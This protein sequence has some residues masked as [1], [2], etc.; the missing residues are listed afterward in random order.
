[1]IRRME[2]LH[3]SIHH[4]ETTQ[5]SVLMHLLQTAKHTTFGKAHQFSTIEIYEDYA[6]RVPLCT[7]E[8]LHETIT[9]IRSGKQ[10]LLWPTQIKW[11]AKSSGTTAGVSKFLPLSYEAI[12]DCHFKGGKDLLALYCNQFPKTTLFSGF[13]LRL[14]GSTS[15]NSN[16][17]ESYFGDLSA[18]LIENL[19]FWVEIRST[20]N[21]RI[22]LMEEWESKIHSISEQAISQ[23]VTSLFGVPS[24]MLVLCKHILEIT[25][26]SHMHE[27]WPN[28]ELYGHGGV[29][30]AP[31][32]KQF[33]AL[34]PHAKMTFMETYNASEGFFAVQDDV[35]RKDMLLL[36]DHGIFYEFLP[37]TEF[38]S[39]NRTAIPLEAVELG[40]NYAMVI[41]TNSG[42]WRYIIG[43]TVK[44]TSTQPYRI[45]IT[46]RTK[47]FIN[48]FGEELIMENAERAISEVCT[49]L[50]ITINEY[51]AAPVYMNEGAAG[52]H[53]WIFEFESPP[54]DLRSFTELFDN[55]L[56]ATNTDYEA[57]RHKNMALQPPIIHIARKNL[58][59]DWLRKHQ[60]LGGQHKVPRLRND[61]ALMDELLTLNQSK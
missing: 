35:D 14:G 18:L 50:K 2:K 20:P 17:H 5:R 37:M 15:V 29:S 7:Y 55:A 49:K 41:S 27:V 24:W 54:E 22:A 46:G 61:R 8:D 13:S 3:F 53:E 23:N 39:A 57:K 38:S 59:H 32:R 19:P 56:K 60:K 12:E 48:A 9:A 58:F 1:M 47:H 25:G 34:F 42:L 11:F 4:A 10:N 40:V 21:Q 51:S 28:M 44:F 33:E 43:D 30:F 26:K 52:A 45:Q 31:Y 36:I 6:K 16:N